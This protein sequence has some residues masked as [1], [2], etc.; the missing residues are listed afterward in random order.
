MA[1]LFQQS[2]IPIY[3]C[4]ER[5]PYWVW[6]HGEKKRNPNKT[7]ITTKMLDFKDENDR[8]HQTAVAFFSKILISYLTSHPLPHPK[9]ALQTV[10][11]IVPSHKAG[12]TSPALERVARDLVKHFG[13]VYNGNPLERVTTIEKLS[14]GGNRDSIVHLTSIRV[15][16]ELIPNYSQVL[17]IDDI[18]TSGNSLRACAELLLQSQSVVSVVP[19]AIAQTR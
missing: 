14:E 4:V 3:Y 19:L 18:T 11:A 1:L 7:N 13:F 5:P 12:R 9:A 17:L 6:E 16:E 15:K 8:N 2:Q 10:I